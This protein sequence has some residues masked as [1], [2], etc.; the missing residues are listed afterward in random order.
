VIGNSKYPDADEPLR[1]PVNDAHL[2]SQALTKA[3]FSVLS[4]VN[5]SSSE[6]RQM[7]E[8]FYAGVKPGSIVIL[9][10]G[11]YAIQSNRQNYLIPVDAQIAQIW[12]E[13]DVRKDGIDLETVLN[14]IHSRGA[15]LKIALI[16]GSRRNPYERRF[17]ARSAGLPPVSAP[18]GTHGYVLHG[19]E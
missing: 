10:F 19:P 1:T 14:D 15:A 6:M 3:S 12:T 4:G 11:G 2:M 9:F 7:L 17:R 13:A 8:Q 16:D 18:T 5:L